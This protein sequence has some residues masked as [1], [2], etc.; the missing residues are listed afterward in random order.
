MRGRT[1]ICADNGEPLGPLFALEGIGTTLPAIGRHTGTLREVRMRL[2]ILSRLVAV[3]AVAVAGVALGVASGVAS[4]GTSHPPNHACVNGQAQLERNKRNVVAYYET[5]FND[6][7]PE[8]AVKLYGGREY[9]QHNPLAGNGFAAFIAFVNSFTT[10]FPD[11]HVDIRRVIA[12][13]DLVVTHAVLTGAP[14]GEFGSKVVD[15]FRV[16]A[17]GKVVEHWDVLAGQVDPATSQNDNSEV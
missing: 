10:S 12:E 8:L 6:K 16:D 13:C 11:I 4:A 2:F 15:I 14:Y 5:A 17:R 9:I 1:P 7:K 3:V